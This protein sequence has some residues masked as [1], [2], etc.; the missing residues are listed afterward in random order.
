MHINQSSLSSIEDPGLVTL[1]FLSSRPFPCRRPL[2]H[3]FSTHCPSSFPHPT[4][5]PHPSAHS[6]R[7]PS[8]LL[9]PRPSSPP[10]HPP[11]TPP[12]HLSPLPFPPMTH[13]SS[14]LTSSPS[15]LTSPL[16]TSLPSSH[17]L[18]F[19]KPT[20]QPQRRQYQ[21]LSKRDPRHTPLTRIGMQWGSE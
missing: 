13:T 8:S 1:G 16:S 10:L 18:L 7:S 21:L 19:F 12:H 6:L 3:T 5:L 2:L 11:R 9:S 4:Q 20:Q 15:L 14:L 17:P